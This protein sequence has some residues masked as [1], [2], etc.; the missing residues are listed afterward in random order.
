MSTIQMHTILQ[1]ILDS[2]LY[3]YIYVCVCEC[4]FAVGQAREPVSANKI[5]NKNVFI[6]S[7]VYTHKIVLETWKK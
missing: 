5:F 3:K 4:L 7:A 6:V 1:S 2:F